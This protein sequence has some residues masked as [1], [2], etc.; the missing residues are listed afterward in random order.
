MNKQLYDRQ[1]RVYGIESTNM[2]NNANVYI[3]GQKSELLFELCKNHYQISFLYI[4][5]YSIC[6]IEQW[7]KVKDQVVVGK[8]LKVAELKIKNIFNLYAAK[9]KTNQ[10]S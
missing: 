9:K 5:C 10:I 4:F 3:Y 1:T 8:N 2:L 6:L 7:K